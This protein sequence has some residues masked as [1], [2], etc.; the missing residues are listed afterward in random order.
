MGV[1]RSRVAAL[2]LLSGAILIGAP[3]AA[4]HSYAMFDRT[5]SVEISGT[6]RTVQWT[7][8]HVY[9]WVNV[10]NDE[11]QTDVW[12]IEFIGGP[13]GLVRR[14]W[15][16]RTLSP[17]DPITMELHPLKDGRTGGM[18]MN[19]TLANGEVWTVEGVQKQE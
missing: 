3:A 10:D 12:G 6:V 13:N 4:H 5:T 18:F 1:A 14:G 16:K 19:V 9:V 7:N 8:P 17:G 2:V 11:G 15:T